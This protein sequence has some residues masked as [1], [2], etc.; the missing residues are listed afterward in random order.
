MNQ[1]TSSEINIAIM[2]LGGLV[3]GLGLLSGWLKERLFLSDPLIALVVG[4]LLSPSVFGLIDLAH[5]GKPEMIL[6]QGA[7]LAIA[8]QVM[9]VALRLPKAY[10]FQHWRIL[11]VLLGLLMPLMW[12]ISGLLVYLLL[13]LPFWV[14]MLV[15]AVIT[16]TD[17]VVSTSVVTGKVAE[18]NLPERI[19]HTISA[20]SA[21]NDGLAYPFVLLPILILTKPPQE[22]LL[23][24]LTKTLLWEVG[25]AVVMGVLIGYLAG[26]LLRWAETK[27]TL[28]K[29]SF[30]AYTVALS[31]AVLGLVKLLGSDGILAVF[32]AG[33]TFDMVVGGRDRAEEE[34]VQEAVDRFFT[35]YIFVLLGL[36]LPWQQ[37]FELGWKGLLLVVAI[38]LLRRLPA[39]LLLRPLLGRLRGV[40]DALFLGWFGPIGVAALFYAFLSVRQAGVEEPWTI[41]SLV[42]CASILVHGCTAVPLAKLYGKQQR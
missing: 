10:P 33:I 25:A 29:E 41:G 13:G 5:W 7:R 8:I 32:A 1:L 4:V 14:A 39:V 31:L 35:L 21:A 23:H 38:L 42:I 19:R 26:R 28:E 24:W 30:L 36:Y 3:L 16:P 27:Q 37:W 9:G 6:E 18:Q 20:E 11:S 40:Q 12:L 34:N 22:A 17:P 2:T 15:G